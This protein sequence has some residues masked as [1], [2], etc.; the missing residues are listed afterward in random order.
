MD[1][2]LAEVKNKTIIK[3]NVDR[4]KTIPSKVQ[5]DDVVITTPT[6]YATISNKKLFLKNYQGALVVSFD[7]T[8]SGKSE[9]INATF[10]GFVIKTPEQR[11]EEAVTSVKYNVDKSK[12]RASVVKTSNFTII[13]SDETITDTK[14]SEINDEAGTLK[15]SYSAVIE[16]VKGKTKSEIIKGFKKLTKKDKLN[17]LS[18]TASL[19]EKVKR[20][21]LISPDS[22]FTTDVVLTSKTSGVTVNKGRFE[23]LIKEGI[24]RVHYTLSRNGATSDDMYSDITDFNKSTKHN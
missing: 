21:E 9:H 16:G 20:H 14:I 18:A 17:K 10:D 13:T 1:Q 8:I 7:V 4:T 22:V 24:L 15:I 11:L 19:I 6:K 23:Y 5:K 2:W 12:V 3:L